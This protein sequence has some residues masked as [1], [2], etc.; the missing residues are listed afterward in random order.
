MELEILRRARSLISKRE[1]WLQGDFI[2]GDAMCASHALTIAAYEITADS[3]C[4]D[5]S[6]WRAIG[7]VISALHGVTAIESGSKRITIME[8]NDTHNH[9]EVLAAF[10]RAI[11]L[12]E[13]RNRP[14]SKEPDNS[15]VLAI[16]T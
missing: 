16:A 12:V 9:E 14:L 3:G 5:D 2:K 6:R 15:P 11:A 7:A 10:D 8:F 1:N 13:A 4:A